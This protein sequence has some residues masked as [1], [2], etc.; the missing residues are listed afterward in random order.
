MTP[1]DLSTLGID[2]TRSARPHR[3][4]RRWVWAIAIVAIIAAAAAAS[5]AALNVIAFVPMGMLPVLGGKRAGPFG[6]GARRPAGPL[7]DFPPGYLMATAL[8]GE[9]IPPGAFSGALT[10]NIS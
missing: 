1:S 8:A 2:R 10:R 9:P 5:K 7:A 4:R 6:A 3:H